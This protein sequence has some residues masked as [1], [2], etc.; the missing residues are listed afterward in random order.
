MLDEVTCLL[1]RYRSVLPSS[2]IAMEASRIFRGDRYVPF[3]QRFSHGRIHNVQNAI[4]TFY[5]AQYTFHEFLLLFVQP[6][7]AQSIWSGI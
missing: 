3:A 7:T 5:D 1:A 6:I 4:P 2:L